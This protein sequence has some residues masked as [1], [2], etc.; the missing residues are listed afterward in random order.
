MTNLARS[1]ASPKAAQT[2]ARHSDINLMM[3]TYTILGL[4]ELVG[5]VEALPPVAVKKP[6]GEGSN[7]STEGGN[8]P[9]GPVPSGALGAQQATSETT[10]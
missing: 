4:Q 3:N 7:G 10:W 2:L 5:D 1:G 6:P 9:P 8:G